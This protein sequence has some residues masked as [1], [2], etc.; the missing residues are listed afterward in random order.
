MRCG[1]SSGV[2]SN[3]AYLFNVHLRRLSLPAACADLF[4][5]AIRPFGFDT[6]ACGELDIAHR[7]R[8]AFYLIDW[9]DAWREFYIRSGL[10]ER[11]PLIDA[12]GERTE[13]FTWSDLRAGKTLSQIGRKALE[14][15]AVAGWSDGL[16]VPVPRGRDRVGLISL[17]GHRDVAGDDKAYLSLISLALHSHVRTLVSQQG[18]ALPPAGLTPREIECIGLVAHGLS[19]KAIG[20]Q[21][22]IA[23]STAHEYVEKAKARLRTRSRTEMV[24]IAAALG[25][26]DI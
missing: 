20:A 16:I 7:E 11:D 5:L 6:F 24:A 15:A 4:R 10:I 23:A 25:I 8:S 2:D 9:P 3:N 1:L 18:F 21:L 19:D 22:D 17:V 14:A 12:L 26:I 13:P